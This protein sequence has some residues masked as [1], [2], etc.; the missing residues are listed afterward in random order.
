MIPPDDPRLEIMIRLVLDSQQGDGTWQEFCDLLP[1]FAK[2]ERERFRRILAEMDAACGHAGYSVVPTAD[3][4]ALRDQS[5]SLQRLVAQVVARLSAGD[6]HMADV[7]E[8]IQQLSVA[9]QVVIEP[10]L[11]SILS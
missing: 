8:Q 1:S 5:L 6:Q 2:V 3:L 10:R 11:K 7:I 9:E 4:I